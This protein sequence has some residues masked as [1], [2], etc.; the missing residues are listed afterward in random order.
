ML[1]RLLN[2][3]KG[4]MQTEC[5]SPDHLHGSFHMTF[6][7]SLAWVAKPH[8]KAIKGRYAHGDWGQFPLRPNEFL[9]DRPHVVVHH[10]NRHP[11][12]MPKEFDMGILETYGLLRMILMLV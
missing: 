5:L 2:G 8:L 6:F 1:I 9:H 7:V 10:L 11:G 12:Q 3:I 4:I